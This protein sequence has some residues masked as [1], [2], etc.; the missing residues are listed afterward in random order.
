M[1]GVRVVGVYV[2]N[3]L[4]IVYKQEDVLVVDCFDYVLDFF[5]STNESN[6]LLDFIWPYGEVYYR[7]DGRRISILPKVLSLFQHEIEVIPVITCEAQFNCIRRELV[8][9][10]YDIFDFADHLQ[11]YHIIRSMWPFYCQ[12]IYNLRP[13]DQV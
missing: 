7:L 12:N 6:E 4:Y 10:W 8:D 13:V 3:L 1:T 5:V 9:H 11:L 2:G